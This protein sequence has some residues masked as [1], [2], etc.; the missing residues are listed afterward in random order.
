MMIDISNETKRLE[1]DTDA[2]Y[3]VTI[4]RSKTSRSPIMA[5]RHTLQDALTFASEASGVAPSDLRWVQGSFDYSIEA[6]TGVH[7][8]RYGWTRQ[9]KPVKPS[10]IE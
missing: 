8:E 3:Q 4:Y 2:R 7:A 9:Y 5:S 1:L 6:F 10:V